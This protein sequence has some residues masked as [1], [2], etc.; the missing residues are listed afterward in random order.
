MMMILL[1]PGTADSSYCV[2]AYRSIALK[3][4]APSLPVEELQ[5]DR[6]LK[7]KP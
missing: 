1:I 4:G 7:L 5:V 2:D 3:K 6:L